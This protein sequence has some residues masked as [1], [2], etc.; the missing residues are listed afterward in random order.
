MVMNCQVLQQK[1]E[2]IPLVL[3]KL[4]E[5]TPTFAMSPPESISSLRHSRAH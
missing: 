3:Q 4:S 2:V 5:A 1:D